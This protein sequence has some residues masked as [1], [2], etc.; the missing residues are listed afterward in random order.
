MQDG[1]HL[2]LR[3]TQLPASEPADLVP[4]PSS[5][6]LAGSSGSAAVSAEASKAAAAAAAGATGNAAASDGVVDQDGL[7][8]QINSLMKRTYHEA[9]SQVRM[10]RSVGQSVSQSHVF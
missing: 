5:S 3:L 1:G 7:A 6:A 8:H 4:P 2:L 10:L 9:E